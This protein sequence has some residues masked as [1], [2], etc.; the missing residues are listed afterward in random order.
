M[1]HIDFGIGLDSIFDAQPDRLTSSALGSFIPMCSFGL[2]Y[3]SEKEAI[4]CEIYQLQANY[5]FRIVT[6]T[7]Q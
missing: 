3:S 2:I 5:I 1:V 6:S 4:W 7:L